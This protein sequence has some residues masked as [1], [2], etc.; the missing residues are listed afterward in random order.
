ME[1][2]RS[3]ELLAQR[4]GATLH[5]IPEDSTLLYS[6]VLFSL[7]SELKTSPSTLIFNVG[8]VLLAFCSIMRS[9]CS[10]L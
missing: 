10:L 3:S 1:A 2:G 7:L 9:F 4:Y 8:S 5:S 6:F